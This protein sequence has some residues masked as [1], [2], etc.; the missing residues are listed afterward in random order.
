MSEKKGERYG[1]KEE[2]VKSPRN[3]FEIDNC[4]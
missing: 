2:Q 1:K 3:D 4:L